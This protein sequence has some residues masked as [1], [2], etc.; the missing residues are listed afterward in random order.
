M[1]SGW[2]RTGDPR[3]LRRGC[4]MAAFRRDYGQN[5]S[6][7]EREQ[8][9]GGAFYEKGQWHGNYNPGQHSHNWVLGLV[10][11]YAITGDESTREAIVENVEFILRAP[12]KRW[13]GWWGSRIPGWSVEGLVDAWSVLGD[14]RCLEEAGKGVAR[15]AELEI[16]DGGLGF[17]LNP[18]NKATQ[19]WMDD[20]FFV[21]AAK[22]VAA[23]GDTAPLPLLAR[24][25]NWFKR[26]CIVPPSGSP[27]SMTLPQVFESWSPAKADKPM[28]HH[29]WSMADALSASAILFDDADDRMWATILFEAAVRYWQEPSGSRS[30]KNTLDA[31]GWSPITMRPLSFPNSESKV[32]SNVL[33]YGVSHLAMRSHAAGLR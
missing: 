29:L 6:Q 4:D 1:L 27:A 23:S 26:C 21:A 20:I 25:R 2:L 30:P 19:S 24:M 31:S 17:H 9:R 10:L 13:T 32:L 15:F 3:L 12:P 5:H 14:P 33:R 16:Q 8:W 11:H 22:Y 28:I 7:D 18:S